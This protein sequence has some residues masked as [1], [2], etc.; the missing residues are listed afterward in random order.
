MLPLTSGESADHTR[1]TT[2]FV[3]ECWCSAAGTN[4]LS[5]DTS[6]LGDLQL[7]ELFG[8]LWHIWIRNDP[9]RD[10]VGLDNTPY[11]SNEGSEELSVVPLGVMC[12][13]DLL[14]LRND[15][16]RISLIAEDVGDHKGQTSHPIL[17]FGVLAGEEDLV[18]LVRL[19]VNS[20]EH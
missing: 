5:D 8:I 9:M 18:R 19:I 6:G 15:T 11:A 3:D 16:T 1:L 12:G 2:F 10:E 4:L 20:D 14:E 17:E 7:C 13:Y